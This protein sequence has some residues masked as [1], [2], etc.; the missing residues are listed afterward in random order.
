MRWTPSGRRGIEDRRA[1]GGGAKVGAGGLI[2]AIVMSLIFGRDFVSGLLSGGGVGGGSGEL[3]TTPEEERKVDFVADML[4]EQEATWR[5]LLGARYQDAPVVLY[6]AGTR[7]GCGYGE[8]A[9]GPFYCPADG[10]VYLDLSFFEVMERELGAGGDF[11]QAYVLA[12]E[13]GHHVQ[14]LTSRMGGPRSNADSVKTELQADCY[15]GVWGHYAA[16]KGLLEQGDLEEGLQA[17]AAIG[18]DTLQR[19]AGRNPNPESFTH[20]SSEDR[21]KWLRRGFER[22]QPDD[23]DTRDVTAR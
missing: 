16:R 12:H 4:H 8:A 22:G 6:R 17:A 23:C 3:R 20:G 7:T 2:L 21:V 10:K 1:L 13:L 9:M 15:A 14:N 18:D 11:A 19:K 5:S